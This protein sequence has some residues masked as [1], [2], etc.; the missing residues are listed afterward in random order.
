MKV[1][2][3]AVRELLRRRLATIENRT[4]HALRLLRGGSG[5]EHDEALAH[6]RGVLEEV[7]DAKK[8]VGE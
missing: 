1:I 4:L 6:L 5:P 2:T 7:S 3:P 8:D